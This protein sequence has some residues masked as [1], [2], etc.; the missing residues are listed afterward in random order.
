MPAGGHLFPPP[1]LINGPA[2]PSIKGQP[3]P[4]SALRPRGPALICKQAE[5]LVSGCWIHETDPRPNLAP[6]V[7]RE[8]QGKER[9]WG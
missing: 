1:P 7:V 5:R 9:S 2:A 3:A 4:G 8:P 6:D